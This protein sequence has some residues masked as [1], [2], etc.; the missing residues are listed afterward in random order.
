[1]DLIKKYGTQG[2]MSVLFRGTIIQATCL[3][4]AEPPDVSCAGECGK[5]LDPGHYFYLHRDG[6]AWHFK[7]HWDAPVQAPQVRIKPV[8]IPVPSVRVKP[9]RLTFGVGDN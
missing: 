4:A 5:P 7:C 3:M 2:M 8:R 1:M 9:Q 6:T